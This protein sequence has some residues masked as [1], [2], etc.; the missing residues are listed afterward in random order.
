MSGSVIR[1]KGISTLLSKC[2]FQLRILC[3]DGRA[4]IGRERVPARPIYSSQSIT[5]NHRTLQ[6]AAATNL[7][8]GGEETSSVRRQ[9]GKVDT[10][11]L[12]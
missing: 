7:S 3:G 10:I 12:S 4:P 8:D 6:V 5:Y 2:K 9:M 1:R 11:F